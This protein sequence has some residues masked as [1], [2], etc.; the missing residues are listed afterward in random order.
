M[1]RTFHSR[2]ARTKRANGWRC[3]CWFCIGS[4]AYDHKNNPPMPDPYEL[5]GMDEELANPGFYSFLREVYGTD[6][7]LE[8]AWD[9]LWI[10][11]SQE[12]HANIQE[13]VIYQ[14]TGRP[15]PFARQNR[16]NWKR[17]LMRRFLASRYWRSEAHTRLFRNFIL[18]LTRKPLTH[19]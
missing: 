7:D 9:W 11:P 4:K 8:E 6:E 3:T 12:L 13:H 1:S 15:L 14:W 16:N 5:E 19:R 18:D 17:R 10:H 2:K